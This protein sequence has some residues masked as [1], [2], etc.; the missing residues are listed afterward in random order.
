M[1]RRQ[2]APSRLSPQEN[3][4]VMTLQQVADYLSCHYT[5]AYKLV[6]RGELPSFRLGVGRISDWR[7]L[8][9]E[10][11]KWTAQRQVTPVE[12]TRRQS[13]MAGDVISASPGR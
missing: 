13:L 12:G 2:A 10:V 1:N 9:S 5:T 4:E 6:R 3:S 7:F 8:R 11:D